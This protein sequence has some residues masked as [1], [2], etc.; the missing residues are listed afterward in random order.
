MDEETK[1][2]LTR[3]NAA[4]RRTVDALMDATEARQAGTSLGTSYRLFGENLSLQHLVDTKTVALRQTLEELGQAQA[5]LL[6]AQKLEAV[7]QLAAGVAHEINTPMQY[8][9]DNLQFLRKAFGRVVGLSDALEEIVANAEAGDPVADLVR[10]AVKR[11]KVAVIKERAPRSIEQALDGVKTVSRIVS[12]MKEFSHPGTEEMVPVQLNQVVETTTTVCRNEWKYV[13]ELEL[14]LAADLPQVI[15]HGN[16]LNQVLLNLVVNA[17]HAIGGFRD[18]AADGK[19]SIRVSTRCRGQ[20][21]YLTVVDTGGGMPP[22]VVERI[23]EPFFTT[24]EVGRGTGQ[25]LAICHQIVRNHNGTITVETEP[26]VGTTFEV[27]I[28]AIAAAEV[29]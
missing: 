17:A 22:Q 18:V 10:A 11:S 14:D 8:I 15:A 13:A 27:C 29:A 23:F 25:G 20:S 5:Q 4:L 12:A 21:I 6:H 3:E 28:P 9:G 7:G 26:G 24:K 2:S 19:G 1:K 16:E